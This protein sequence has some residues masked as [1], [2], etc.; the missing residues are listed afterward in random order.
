MKYMSLF[1]SGVF[2]YDLYVFY[3]NFNWNGHLVSGAI[4][5]GFA[6][7]GFFSLMFPKKEKIVTYKTLT[8]IGD[9]KL[10]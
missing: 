5:G 8:K 3:S 4:L 1:F 10:N 6:I 7:Y 2:I 9:E